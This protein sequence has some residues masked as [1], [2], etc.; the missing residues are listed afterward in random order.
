MRIVTAI[1]GS[2]D[3]AFDELWDRRDQLA[4]K[5]EA[6][7]LSRNEP[8]PAEERVPKSEK[9]VPDPMSLIL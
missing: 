2:L 5:A 4:P 3:K 7:K 8:N 1:Y 6:E 9:S